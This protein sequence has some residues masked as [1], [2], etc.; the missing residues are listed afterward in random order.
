MMR[1]GSS[2]RA[3]ALTSVVIGAPVRGVRPGPPRFLVGTRERGL[4]L[5]IGTLDVVAPKD[6]V[7]AV[8]TFELPSPRP[9][10]AGSKVE[11]IAEHP[12]PAAP[13][14]EMP[15]IGSDAHLGVEA[16]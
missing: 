14:E 16:G 8:T 12:K 2:R 1:V 9:R 4:N 13:V 3:D 10:A 5:P 15:V 6:L 7:H 11:R